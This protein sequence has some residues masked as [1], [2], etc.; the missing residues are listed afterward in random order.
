MP[1]ALG[2]PIVLPSCGA[3]SMGT[4]QEGWGEEM[5][6]KFSPACSSPCGPSREMLGGM[7]AGWGIAGEAVA[8]IVGNACR[9]ARCFP[10]YKD[11][12]RAFKGSVMVPAPLRSPWAPCSDGPTLC[13]SRERKTF[14]DLHLLVPS[15]LLSSPSS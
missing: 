12:G 14:R 15:C 2:H 6:K 1:C 10:W 9:A 8:G 5:Q 7:F 11:F 13:S 4:S 3:G